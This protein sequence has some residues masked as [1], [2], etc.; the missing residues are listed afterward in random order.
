MGEAKFR[1]ELLAAGS[2]LLEGGPIETLVS[3]LTNPRGLTVDGAG[4]V[5]FVELRT[6]RLSVF[7]PEDER[8]YEALIPTTASLPNAIAAGAEGKIWFLEYMGNKVGVFDP[9]PA[10]F[11]E[12]DIPT[13]ASL[14]GDMAIDALRDR[15]W[16]SESNTESKRLGMLAM[17]KARAVMVGVPPRLAVVAVAVVVPR[18]KYVHVN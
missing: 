12:F 16:F 2:R 3:G 5:W 13:Y 18:I 17:D 1:D 4:K 11:T 7:Y 8:F 9:V 10:K 15:L 6:N 14:P